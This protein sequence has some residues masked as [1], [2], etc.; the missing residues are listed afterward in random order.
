MSWALPLVACLCAGDN[1]GLHI[2]KRRHHFLSFNCNQCVDNC[3][4][5][6][7]ATVCASVKRGALT[8]TQASV[9]AFVL[10]TTSDSHHLSQYFANRLGMQLCHRGDQRLIWCSDLHIRQC[11]PN[12]TVFTSASLS[13][14]VLTD[15]LASTSGRVQTSFYAFISARL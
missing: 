13:A 10:S 5:S 7:P 11:F 6:S 8:S 4:F 2:W 15:A 9:S 14:I 3:V 12:L 1:L